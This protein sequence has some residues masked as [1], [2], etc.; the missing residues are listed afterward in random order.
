MDELCLLLVSIFFMLLSLKII[1][2]GECELLVDF[3]EMELE[4]VVQVIYSEY[5]D[6][7]Q[8]VDVDMLKVW[9]QWVWQ[10]VQQLEL[11]GL[12]VDVWFLLID[13]GMCY[14]G[15]QE[16]LL[17]SLLWIICQL[18]EVVVFCEGEEI[19]GEVMQIML[20]CW[21][22]CEGYLVEC[23]QDEI[24]Q[25]QILIEIEGE[26]V[27]QI[28][29]FLVIE[30][31]GYLCVFGEF[32]CISCVVYI[33]DGEFIDVECK[34]ELGGNIYVKGMMIMQVFLMFELELE[35]QFFFIVLLIFEQFYS[36]VDGD[37]VFMVEFCVLISVL[38]NVLINQSIVIIGFVDQFGCVQLVGGLNEKIEGFFIICQQCGLIGKQGVII[39]VVNV[40][41]FSLSYELCQVVVDNQFVIWVIDDIIEVLLMLIQLMWD[42]EGQML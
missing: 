17:F 32:L 34:V 18:W 19:I 25:E 37:S 23:M 2:V 20:V 26:C 5:E 16:I 4:L 27:G 30:F 36:E 8:F 33:G 29:V 24:L 21:V 14:I 28:N 39:F 12:V 9:C 6:I 3:Q 31:F 38:V 13:E 11:L 40:C 41:Y 7:L 15:D 35:Q 1:L 42:G 10:N 22:W